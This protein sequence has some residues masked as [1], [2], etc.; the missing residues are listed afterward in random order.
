MSLTSAAEQIVSAVNEAGFCVIP[1]VLSRDEATALRDIVDQL[2]ECESRPDET[3]LGHRRVLHIAAKHPAFVTLLCHPLVM[4]VCEMYLGPDFVCSTW[5]SNT[6]LPGADLTYWHVD[7]PYWTI[8]PPYPVEP[9]LT[10][11][12]IWCLDDFS[13]NSGATKFVPG[14]HRRPH[15]PEHN[16]NYDHEGVTIEAPAGSL[17]VA[18]G[19]TWHSAGRNRGVDPRTGIFGRYAR[20]FIVLQEE[21]KSQLAAIKGPEA[22]V[23]R[24]LGKYQYVPQRGF[25]Y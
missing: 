14:S 18:H 9:P 6:A 16:A 8:A 19:A 7:H 12:A 25:P 1:S 24:L 15:L 2:R 23:E 4:A 11:H 13:E 3:H 17:I 21:M 20:S 5:T 22:Q 10:A